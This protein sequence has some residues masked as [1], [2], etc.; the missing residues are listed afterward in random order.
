MNKFLFLL[1]ILI[2]PLLT[3]GQESVKV[4]ALGEIVE[5][6]SEPREENADFVTVEIKVNQKV[7]KRFSADGVLFPQII[8][9]FNWHD[10]EYVI[11]RTDMGSG[12]CASGSVYVL[13]FYENQ[14]NSGLS[15]VLV[16]PVLTTC[17]GEYPVFGINFKGKDKFVLSI[18]QHE[19]DLDN[20]NKWV[21]NKPPAKKVKIK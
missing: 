1:L 19:L 9:T 14:L 10:G 12:V 3:L 13:R 20:F 7:I 4:V 17:L 8:G 6:I 5:I 15:G 18:A 11:Y 16:S 2:S 21:E